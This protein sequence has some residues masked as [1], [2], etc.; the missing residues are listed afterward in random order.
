MLFNN[1]EEPVDLVVDTLISSL[2]SVRSDID[3]LPSV[4]LV[5]Q[6]LYP[7]ALPKGQCDLLIGAFLMIW[8]NLGMMS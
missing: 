5:D 8:M 3:R 4:R 2:K 7:S 1:R 6:T